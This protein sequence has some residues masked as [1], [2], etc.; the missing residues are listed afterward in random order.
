[1]SNCKD[2]YVKDVKD[3]SEVCRVQRDLEN[4]K[5]ALLVQ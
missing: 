1:M 4:Q 2:V 3:E 5:K